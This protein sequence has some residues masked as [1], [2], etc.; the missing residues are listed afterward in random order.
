MTRQHIGHRPMRH[1]VPP[2]Y[3][4]RLRLKSRTDSAGYVDGAWWPRSRDLAAE[5]PDVLAVLGVRLG[6][7]W[8]VV[9]DPEGWTPAPRRLVLG[10][11]EIRLDTY[12]FELFNT[13]YVFGTDG[14]V[15]VLRV[16][17]SA[18]HADL[19]HSALMAAARRS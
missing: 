14:A 10:D 13:M 8:R 11:R 19:A 7:V 2:E 5:L 16:I 6:P 9:Y 18:T 15:V 3:T 17:P 12:A 1:R 4:P